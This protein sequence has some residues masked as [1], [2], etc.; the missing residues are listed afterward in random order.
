MTTTNP[1]PGTSYL[2]LGRTARHRWWLPLLGTFVV[3]TFWSILGALFA[4]ASTILAGAGEAKEV[5][6]P[7]LVGEVG[8]AAL[9]LLAIAT[10]IPAV[11][12]GA[13]YLQGRPAGTVSSVEGR[14]RW[15][16]LWTCVGIATVTTTL[17]LAGTAAL[18]SASGLELVGA[19][20]AWIGWGPFLAS[21]V[22]LLLTV[23]LQAA[24]E[25]YF[26]RGWLMQAIG[27]YRR[28]PWIAIAV[29]T[30]FFAA[31]HGWQGP[32]ALGFFTLFAIVAGVLTLRTGGLE[33]AIGLHVVNNVL[34]VGTY[35]AFGVLEK[36][37]VPSADMGW[38]HV[39]ADLALV[40]VYTGIVLWLARRRGI[41]TTTPAAPA[42]VRELV[43]AA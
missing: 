21:M 41:A 31:A 33:A 12:F 43:H 18:V 24:G 26:T 30:V 23:P 7:P 38:Q 11:F 5:N 22:V 27:A 3:M 14:L 8:S 40:C 32:W 39:A 1:T 28:R 36:V 20:E 29:Q 15:R 9:A 2:H 42:P 17:G 37:G 13:R 6:I 19:D 25:E 10:V 4:G 34:A 16:W 35:A